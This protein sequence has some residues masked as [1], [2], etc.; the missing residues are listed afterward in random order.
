MSLPAALRADVERAL[1][2][3]G[4]GA[5]ILRATP[6]GGG[7]IHAGMRIDT[8]A[9]PRFLKWSADAP[10][11]LF[12][13]EAEGLDALRASGGV[14]VPEVVAVGSGDGGAPSWL[15]LEHID[16]RPRTPASDE[17]LG[18]GLARVHASAERRPFGWPRDNWI[19]SAPQENAPAATWAEFWRDRRIV[20]RLDAARRGGHLLD[21]TLDRLVEVIPSALE[22]VEPALLHGDLWS[23][24]ALAA[25]GDEPVLIDPAVHVGDGEVDLAMSELFGGFAPTFKAAYGAERGV[26][27][28]YDS[29][30]RDLYQLHYL[31][32]HVVLFGGGYAASARR[33]AERVLAAVG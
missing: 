15:L 12:E 26:S 17:R 19:G 5:R 8:D 3:A 22:D 28:A 30:K 20:P 21:E 7:C 33:A 13:R 23:G 18:R 24:N 29:H 2:A 9:G 4:A 10:D 16:T 14:R 27:H 25:P 11:G 31:L 1:A 32:V 6:V